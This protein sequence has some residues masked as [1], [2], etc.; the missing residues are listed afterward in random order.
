MHDD[1]D[2]LAL[3]RAAEAAAA[4]GD[5][6]IAIEEEFRAI[7]RGLSE[8]G[9]VTTFPGTTAHGFAGLA[10]VAFPGA[11]ESLEQAASLF[12]GVRYLGDAGTENG[13]IMIRSLER[14]LRESKPRLDEAFA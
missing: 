13:W 11:G 6:D 3:R 12:D 10:S 9:V 2:A 4:A 14:T 5:Y 7:A 1:R 8:R